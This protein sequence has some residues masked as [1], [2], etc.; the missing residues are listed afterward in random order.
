MS[1]L[2]CE[3]VRERYPDVLNE[4][5]DF[6]AAQQVRAHLLSCDD[7]RA[8][9]ELV[10]L[11]HAAR[12]TAPAELF[13]RVTQAIAAPKHRKPVS[14]HSMVLAA[15]VAIALIGGSVL[16]QL[17]RQ[18]A[19]PVDAPSFGFVSVEDAMLSGKASLDDLSEEELEMLLV[20]ME[21]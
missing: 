18:S 4:R 13:E 11:L 15:S 2:N 20:E 5:A 12:V 8:E 1:T 14:R 6:I 7:C 3:H 19:A 17:E 21:S 10:E 9:A 16:L